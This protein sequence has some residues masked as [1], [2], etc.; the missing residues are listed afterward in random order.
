[1]IN[2]NSDMLYNKFGYSNI[3]IVL[4]SW[5]FLQRCEITGKYNSINYNK[6]DLYYRT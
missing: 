6:Y 5:Y 2:N 4:H 3:V 1:M